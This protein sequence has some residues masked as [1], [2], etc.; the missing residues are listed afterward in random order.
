MQNYTNGLVNWGKKSDI[1]FS[2][3]ALFFNVIAAN[4]VK[5]H[6]AESS[7]SEKWLLFDGIV[8][9]NVKHGWKCGYR[10][11]YEC[12]C[13]SCGLGWFLQKMAKIQERQ[14]KGLIFP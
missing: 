2:A 12:Q 4:S 13:M 11:Y 3:I 1:L 14:K 10:F 8:A 9:E 5:L 6:W 7:V